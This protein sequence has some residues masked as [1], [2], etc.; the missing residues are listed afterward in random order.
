M[1]GGTKNSGPASTDEQIK[2][3]FVEIGDEPKHGSWWRRLNPFVS[4]DAPPV[5]KEDAGMVPE[6]TAGFW[7]HLTWGWMGPLMMVVFLQLV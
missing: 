3:E 6:I 4:G 5:P 2:S 1:S 7:G